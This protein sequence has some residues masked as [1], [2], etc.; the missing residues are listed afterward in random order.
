MRALLHRLA[1]L[2]EDLIPLA[3]VALLLLATGLAR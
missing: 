2:A 1:P 3:V